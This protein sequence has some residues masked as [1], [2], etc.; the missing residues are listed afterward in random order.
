[1]K[2]LYE[3]ILDTGAT[4]EAYAEDSQNL[5]KSDY[6]IIKKDRCLD[7]GRI[8]RYI[9][10]L[11]PALEKELPE[12]TRKATMLDKSKANENMMRAKS[13]YRTAHTQIEKSKL[14]MKLL[15]AHYT[16]DRKL[17]SFQFTANGRI[18]FRELVKELS[19]TLNTRI[20]LRQIGVRD[21]TSIVG[22]FGVC[23]QVL[24]CKRFLK[25]FESINVKTAKEQDLSLNPVNISGVCG[26]LKCCL[27]Y[28]HCGYLELDKDMPRRG[29]CCECS[30][31]VG[32]IVDRNL[33]TQQVTVCID[34][35]STYLVCPKEEVR[36]VYPDKY[37][38]SG[39]SKKTE[40]MPRDSDDNV[41]PDEIAELD[42]SEEIKEKKK[43][44]H[45]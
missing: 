40:K 16:F 36:V 26:R 44:Q 32:K 27:K 12:I 23:G 35:S 45:N 5:K 6:C 3:I 1:M 43:T 19:Q 31:G 9:G 2:L 41:I 29:A 17:V 8:N 10:S 42:D 21:E 38:I 39:V 11:A 13:A 18:D 28:E 15:N 24:C 30:E 20:D 25:E 33:L 14:Q 22:G 34:K 37:K 7:Y 4:Y